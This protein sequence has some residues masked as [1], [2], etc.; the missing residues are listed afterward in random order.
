MDAQVK[1]SEFLDL[2]NDPK[3][4]PGKVDDSTVEE[5]KLTEHENAEISIDTNLKVEETKV[6]K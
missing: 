2:A 5:A 3:M 6:Y 4:V 1:L